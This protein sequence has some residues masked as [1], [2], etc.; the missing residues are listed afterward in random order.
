MEKWIFQSW[1]SKPMARENIKNFLAISSLSLDYAHKSGYKV[2]MHTDT[3]GYKLLK[4]LGYDDIVLTLDKIP[5]DASTALFAQ[6]KYYAMREE[7]VGK[8]HVDLDVFLKKPCLDR[9]YE[10]KRFDIVAQSEEWEYNSYEDKAM[11]MYILGYPVGVNPSSNQPVVNVGVIGFN[12]QEAMDK[13]LGVYFE[14]LDMYTNEKLEKFKK[15]YVDLE[16]NLDF[17]LEQTYLAQLAK[18]YNL[19][20]LVNGSKTHMSKCADLIGYAHI[21]GTTKYIIYDEILR[22][23]QELNPKLYKTVMKLISK[24]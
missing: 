14:A 18:N 1:W 3:E 19:L 6:G 8:V 11:A 23:L 24:L 20:T 22:R 13:Y 15:E 21:W 4:H 17:I 5:E 10:E 12:N 9:F 2:R 7:G 16:V